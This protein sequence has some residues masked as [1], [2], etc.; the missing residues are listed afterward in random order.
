MELLWI[1][2]AY[3]LVLAGLLVGMGSLGDRIGRRRLLFVGSAGFAAVS[4]VTAFAPGA[5]W[6]IAG[7]A[8]LGFFGAMLM[9]SRCR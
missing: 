1:V 9:P 2:D 7:R 4:A 6:L 8:G 5:A 3:P